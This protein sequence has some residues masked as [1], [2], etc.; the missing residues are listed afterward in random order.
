MVLGDSLG[1]V[2][3]ADLPSALFVTLGLVTPMLFSR[4]RVGPVTVIAGV[5][6]TRR[7][8]VITGFPVDDSQTR[9]ALGMK[10][11]QPNW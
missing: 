7:P 11:L 6:W 4:V 5:T 10:L 2:K 8:D 3:V 1:S 9:L